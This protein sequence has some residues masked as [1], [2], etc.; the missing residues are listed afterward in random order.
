MWLKV[1]SLTSILPAP[2]ADAKAAVDE[3]RHGYNTDRRTKR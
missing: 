1:S 2:V 3:V